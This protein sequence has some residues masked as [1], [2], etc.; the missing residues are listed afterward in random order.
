MDEKIYWG[1]R[2]KKASD[3]SRI[4]ENDILTNRITNVYMF[5]VVSWVSIVMII[6]YS[7]YFYRI[8]RPMIV[9][10]AMFVVEQ[11]LYDKEDHKN[12]VLIL[13]GAFAFV[14]VIREL[15]LNTWYY[16]MENNSLLSMLL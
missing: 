2:C 10:S 16:A 6:I 11:F 1:D 3:V 12:W 8:N 4:G 9:V 5:S 15:L 7:N 13:M 14:F